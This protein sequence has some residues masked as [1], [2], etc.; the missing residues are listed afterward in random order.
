MRV[1]SGSV[2]VLEAFAHEIARSVVTGAFSTD[3]R[4]ALRSLS[5][6][7]GLSVVVVL[8][9][10]LGLAIAVTVVTVAYAYVGRALPY[11]AADRLYTLEWSAP[12]ED[13]PPNLESLDWSS[14]GDLV[15][16]PIAW[17]L[18]M[19]YLLGGA[20][21]ESL[22]GAWV[23]RGFVEAL[24][25][26]ASLGRGFAPEDFEPGRAPVALISDQL[27]RSR[28][29][30]D[31]GVLGRTFQ[32]YVSD[33]PDEAEQFTIVGVL[34]S[35]FWHLNPY[36]DVLAPL[37]ARTYPY[38]V[39]AQRGVG[40][41]A[42]SDRLTAFVRGGVPGLAASWKVTV[43]PTQES[44][45]RAVRPVLWAIA[46]AAG[47]VLLIACAN[48][49][50]LML[51]RGHRRLRDLSVRMALGA[52]TARITT[53]TL[54]ESAVLGLAAAATGAV[55][56]VWM[57]RALAPVL[58]Q[59]IGRRIPGGP[60][61]LSSGLPVLAMATA[62]GVVS[63]VASSFAPFLLARRTHESMALA[64]TRTATEGRKAA[65]LRAWFLIVEVAASLALVAGASLLIASARHM[66]GVD[67]GFRTDIMTAGT[68]LRQQ[69]YPTPERLAGFYERLLVEVAPFVA[70]GQAAA[71]DWWP[72]QPSRRRG[73]SI[74]GSEAS[75]GKAGVLAVTA[76]YFD[77]AGIALL[78]G[79]AFSD[80]DRIGTQPV[81]I[82]SES[83]ARRL[84]PQSPA[85]GQ[86]LRVDPLDDDRPGPQMEVVI[87]GV[88]G[89]VRQSHTDVELD[90]LYLPLLQHPGRFGYLYLRGPGLSQV[91]HRVLRE[92]VRR[93]GPE[94]AISAP[95]LLSTALADLRARPLW[96]AGVLTAFAVAAAG[97]ALVGLYAV[98]VYAVSQRQREVAVRMAIGA[99]PWAILRLFLIEGGRI[100]GAGLAAGLVAA[101]AI[102]RV[103]ESQL[104]GVSPVEPL[105]L[106]AAVGVLTLAG[107][108]AIARPARK[109]ASID[110][111]GALKE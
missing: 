53:L 45:T 94:A 54:I 97:L 51:V 1:S 71:T 38:M 105:P 34:P 84:W 21:P 93:A 49:S 25:I 68:S 107:F 12:G 19:F 91:P 14:L 52:S 86:S 59:P 106:V 18:D 11:P 15:E 81:A 62:F 96:L 69:S 37:T 50:I 102:G 67:L 83:M 39:R 73:L 63:I 47:L 48:V 42:M 13:A 75:I 89:D 56:S 109:A 46:T 22:P 36:T 111:A 17:D 76:A 8:T 5:A 108:L 77:A 24:G 88:V 92:A 43:V 65:R 35:G 79:R 87:V 44:Y 58:E 23:T 82:A 41:S 20:Y 32:A 4:H 66:L 101:L 26:R 110:P 80:A 78:D 90:D 99:T 40:P 31:E 70:G 6:S 30:G 33:R 74:A 9:L 2:Q 55:A 61:L 7:R 16:H 60:D 27:W 29:G 57:L 28:F 100:L 98:V 104:F 3:L 103:L 85:V 72:L 95:R 10:G 64:S